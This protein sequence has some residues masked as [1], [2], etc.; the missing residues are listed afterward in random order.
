M[1][2]AGKQQLIEAICKDGKVEAIVVP[3]TKYVRFKISFLG[4]SII[5]L[6]LE[7]SFRDG[8]L[9][10]DLVEAVQQWF[11]QPNMVNW[12]KQHVHVHIPSKIVFVDKT[13]INGKLLET[14]CVNDNP[15]ILGL[16]LSKC[17]I[18]LE[19]QQLRRC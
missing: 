13:Y 15:Y 11:T 14:A 12:A 18:V 17:M 5:K 2:L 16:D 9:G 6:N 4:T 19:S 7:T 10:C 3:G 8:S 1:N